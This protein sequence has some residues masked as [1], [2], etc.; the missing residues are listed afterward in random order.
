MEANH[1]IPSENENKWVAYLNGEEGSLPPAED[2]DGVSD[3]EQTW[4]LAGIAYCHDNV[5][6][7]AA[8]QKV[9]EQVQRP[10]MRVYQYIIPIVRYAAMLIVVA[11]VAFAARYFLSDKKQPVEYQSLI[12]AVTVSN[13]TEATIVTLPDGSTVQLNA[14]TQL[15]YPEQFSGN[16]R[17]V[18]LSGEAY[19]QV[20]H[21]PN[22][23]F[24]IETNQASIEVLGTSFN[25]SAYPGRASVEVN[26]TTGKV[27]LTEMTGK[28]EEKANAV[29]PAGS[30]GR[31]DLSTG[32]IVMHNYLSSNYQ[33][34]IT[35][36]IEFQRTPLGEAFSLLEDIYHVRIECSDPEIA[37]MPYTA[38]FANLKIDYIVDVI[39]KTYQLDVVR[40]DKG[41]LFT[42]R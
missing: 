34:W 38:N 27:R 30:S 9:S 6:V 18:R 40:D 11:G 32:A 39:A 42:K 2:L 7:D 3:L 4:E 25:V 5:D 23:P 22:M 31:V 36:E 13:P 1:N 26:V 24:V 15:Q 20:A 14:N 28:S 17:R 21:N 41:Y 10:R 16:Y 37:S 35:K 29:L 19:F 12:S 8:W 33:A